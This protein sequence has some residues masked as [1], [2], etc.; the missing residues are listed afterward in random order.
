MIVVGQFLPQMPE[1]GCFELAGFNEG[2][3]YGIRM[4]TQLIV[5][6]SN[7]SAFL[8]CIGVWFAVAG[9][10]SDAILIKPN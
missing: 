1:N 8:L 5:F 9:L 4:Q 2:C 10:R 6:W 7:I 3:G